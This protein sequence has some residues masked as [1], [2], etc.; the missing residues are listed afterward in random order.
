MFLSF[1]HS[2]TQS[3]SFRPSVSQFDFVVDILQLPYGCDPIDP[4]N[5]VYLFTTLFPTS[6]SNY[7]TSAAYEFYGLNLLSNDDADDYLLLLKNED[8]DCYSFNNSISSLHSG[9]RSCSLRECVYVGTGGVG[10]STQ[11][12]MQW[13]YVFNVHG[14][15]WNICYVRPQP[16]PCH[17]AIVV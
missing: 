10:L 7:V 6:S 14:S 11:S 4:Q 9:W 15:H 5:T 17:F 2:F 12:N 8:V 16:H 1:I 13:Y 3:P